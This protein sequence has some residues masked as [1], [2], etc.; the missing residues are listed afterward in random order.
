MSSTATRPWSHTSTLLRGAVDVQTGS[1]THSLPR[2]V[3]LCLFLSLPFPLSVSLSHT[4]SL[5]LPLSPPHTPSLSHTHTHTRTSGPTVS[6]FLSHLLSASP[7]LTHTSGLNSRCRVPH[8]GSLPRRGESEKELMPPDRAQRSLLIHTDTHT[9]TRWQEASR[10]A[11]S[12]SLTGQS[13][14]MVRMQADMVGHV[15]QPASAPQ[16]PP[17]MGGGGTGVTLTCCYTH[18]DTHTV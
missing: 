18:S 8:T 14:V 1:S 2:C 12:G 16:A 17:G 9:H 10:Q 4:L 13:R 11:S 5:T 3:S 6:L 7:R 15:P